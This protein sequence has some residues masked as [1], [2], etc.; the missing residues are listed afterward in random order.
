MEK[1]WVNWQK[2][3][4][5]IKNVYTEENLFNWEHYLELNKDLVSLTSKKDA[6]NHWNCIGYKQ[7]R[8]CNKIQLEVSNEFGNELIIYIPYYYYLHINNLLFDNKIT[9][10]KGMKPFYYLLNNDALIEKENNRN[11]SRCPFLVNYTDY[12]QFLDKQYS[13]PPPYKLIYKNDI[14]LFSKPIL[15]IHNKY[16]IEWDIEPVNFIDID[17]LRYTF[18][19]LKDKYQIVYIRP[20]KKK[21]TENFSMDHNDIIDDVLPDYDLIENEFKDKIIIFNDL[22]KQYNYIYNKLLLML[23]SNSTNYICSQGGTAA[24]ITYFYNKLIILHK[25]GDELKNNS[26]EGWYKET[27]KEENKILIICKNYDEIINNLNIF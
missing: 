5:M 1:N 25:K 23:Y 27:N 24:F 22:L 17:T 11:W 9:T 18:N 26:Y 20:S 4:E 3:L 7:M 10:Y 6:E 12:V 14:V 19:K 15:V 21:N 2:Y 8:L 13:T 16:N